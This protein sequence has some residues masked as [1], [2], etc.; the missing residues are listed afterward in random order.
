[1][2]VLLR[3]QADE[4]SGQ[5]VSPVAYLA[6]TLRNPET[7]QLFLSLADTHGL[8]LDDCSDALQSCTVRF[9]D[10]SQAESREQVVLTKIGFKHGGSL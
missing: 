4:G 7:Y 3:R 2:A 9:L 10:R 5:Q 8:Q 6:T 1:M